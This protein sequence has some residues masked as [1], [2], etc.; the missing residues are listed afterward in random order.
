MALAISIANEFLDLLPGAELEIEEENPYLQLN[1]ELLGGYSF[2]IEVL[3][4]PKNM[5]LLGFPGTMEMRVDSTGIEAVIYDNGIPSI[6]GK[7]KIEKPS[8][9]MNNMQDGRISIYILVGAASF[10]QDIKDRKLRSIDVGGDRSFEFTGYSPTTGFWGHVTGVMR[11]TAG[12]GPSGYDYA[13]FPIVNKSWPG[14]G[15]TDIMNMVYLD[16]PYD[17]TFYLKPETGSIGDGEANRIVPFPYLKYV[18]IQ[19]AAYAGWTIAGSMLDDDDFKKI[20]LIN[21]R[22][23]DWSYKKKDSDW[24]VVERDPVSFNL[25]DHLPN[26]NISALFI[27]IRN[28]MGLRYS[29][30]R[31]TKTMYVERMDDVASGT[32]KDFTVQA[33]PLVVKTINQ[34]EK[35]YALINQ[36]STDLGSGAPNFEVVERDDDV[37]EIADL[38]AAAEALYGHVRLVISENNFYICQ[39]NTD[40]EAWEWILYAYNIY[41]YLPENKNEDII[42]AATTIGVEFYNSYLDLLPR[43]DQQGYWFGKTE[44]EIDWG[45][46][47]CFNHGVRDN[48]DDKKYPYGSSHVYDSKFI[49]VAEWALTF[50]CMLAGGLVDVGLYEVFWRRILA[51]LNSSEEADVKLYLSRVDQMKL[52]FEDIIAVRNTRHFIKT[53]KPKIPYNGEIDLRLVRI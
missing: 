17:G 43:V 19:A 2:P 9:N 53:A 32:V 25:Q 51:M 27:A 23:I 34:E 22:A 21:F 44:E 50:E 8:I 42:T 38:P 29:W 11:G 5:R 15:N 35:I 16:D 45:I 3:A 26:I 7:I 49:Q 48:K 30:D 20:V 41:D 39:Q 47:L 10:W 46:I 31:A 40:T 36:F 6:R 13:F 14:I 52:A 1:D 4:T 33:S 18:M 37:D 24:I 28:R 12:Y